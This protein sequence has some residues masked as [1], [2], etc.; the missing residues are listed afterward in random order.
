MYQL[1]QPKPL[2]HRTRGNNE[3]KEK[4]YTSGRRVLF[5]SYYLN[6][7]ITSLHALQQNNAHTVV[8]LDPSL[9]SVGTELAFKQVSFIFAEWRIDHS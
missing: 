7:F 8:C 2:K 9:A 3:G 1:N 5:D 6:K 4:I